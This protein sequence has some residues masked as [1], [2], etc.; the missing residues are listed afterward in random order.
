VDIPLDGATRFSPQEFGV[1]AVRPIEAGRGLAHVYSM[2]TLILLRHAKAVRDTEAPTDRARVLT[3][4]GRQDAAAAGRE[5]AALG[6]A[7]QVA[8]VSPAA[9][10]QETWAAIAPA[11]PDAKAETLEALYLAEAD[12]I[13]ERA[14]HQADDDACI[15]VVGHNPG[16]HSLAAHLVA[17]AYDHS[18]TAQSIAEHLPTAALAAFAVQPGPLEAANPRLLAAWRPNG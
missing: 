11:C 10:T 3:V 5:I 7:V 9:R 16:L 12:A 14:M 15:L 1:R 2:A 6:L 4:R 17:Q 13:W 18:R 8:L